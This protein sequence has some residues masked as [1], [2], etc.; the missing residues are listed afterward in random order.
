M[1]PDH[2]TTEVKEKFQ[3]YL[4]LI[5]TDLCAKDNGLNM[6]TFG[7]YTFQKVIFQSNKKVTIQYARSLPG[8]LSKRL[9]HQMASDKVD[10]EQI[11][12]IMQSQNGAGGPQAQKKSGQKTKKLLL[13]ERDKFIKT[14][15]AI[16]SGSSSERRSIIFKMQVLTPNLNKS[17]LIGQILRTVAKYQRVR[18]EWHST[19]CCNFVIASLDLE[20]LK[21]KVELSHNLL[22]WLVRPDF[23]Q[24]FSI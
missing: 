19:T 18:C 16:Y 10:S 3:K 14:I 2:V 8:F 4:R 17:L 5:F 13:A 24:F 6:R 21:I 7:I 1:S 9:Y 11:Q 20:K 23:H 22:Q 15:M 12:A